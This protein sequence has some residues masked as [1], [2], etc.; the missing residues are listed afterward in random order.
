MNINIMIRLF[1]VITLLTFSTNSK[2][3]SESNIRITKLDEGVWLH[4]SYYVYPN[5]VKFPSNGL[6]VKEGENLTLVDTA[7][8]ELQTVKLLAEIELKIKLPVTK[9]LV[10]HAHSDRAA[11]VDVL[12]AAGIKVFSHPLTQKF[13]IEQ[14][15]PVPDNVINE[16][17]EAGSSVNF[18]SLNVFFP[19]AGHA[20][21]NLVVWLPQKQILFGGC[22][23]RALS[24]NSAGNTA[25]GDIDSW[26]II[27]KQLKNKYKTAAMVIPGHG[28]VGG[29]ELLSHTEEL[30]IDTINQ[31]SH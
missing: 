16:L 5:G 9:A 26:L 6:I 31:H 20:L 1:I 8:G 19:G 30:I 14:G 12:E 21:D 13:S 7:W 17:K 29:I 3:E 2:A 18:G 27:T 15:A 25:H 28:E 10:T 11:G 4:T 22:A 23:I 24:A